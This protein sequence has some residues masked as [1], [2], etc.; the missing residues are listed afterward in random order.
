MKKS[1]LLVAAIA[2]AML[3]FTVA[4]QESVL[5]PNANKALIEENLLIGLTTENTGLQRGSALMLGKIQSDRGVIP[6]MEALHNN[7]DENVRIAAAW[8]LCK[9]GDARGA[10]TVKRSATFDDSKR[11]QAACAWYYENYIQEGSFTF[12]QPDYNL[13]AEVE[14]SVSEYL[15]R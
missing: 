1:L 12:N 3:T 10:Y 2:L 15:S 9:I 4:A 5:P 8:A 7:S 11:V 14:Y 6:L 13:V